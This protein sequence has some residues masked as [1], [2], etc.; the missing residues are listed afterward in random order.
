MREKEPKKEKKKLGAVQQAGRRAAFY[1]G[2][3]SEYYITS[4]LIF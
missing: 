3:K 4:L 1:V 2:N